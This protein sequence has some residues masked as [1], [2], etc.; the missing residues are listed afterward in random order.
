MKALGKYNITVAKEM[1]T[2]EVTNDNIINELNKGHPIIM[3]VYHHYITLSLSDDGKILV[4]D[5][6]PEYR[7]N[8][9]KGIKEF[10]SVEDINK[11]YGEI[12]LAASYE[13]EEN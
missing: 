4:L 12:S 2:G 13:L 1:A 6:T 5:P 3:N 9:E 7:D 8:R 10:D 11:V